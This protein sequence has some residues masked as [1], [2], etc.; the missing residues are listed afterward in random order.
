MIEEIEKRI[1]KLRSLSNDLN[2][3]INDV[4]RANASFVI[5]LNVEQQQSGVNAKNKKIGTY[6]ESTKKARKRKGLQ[7]SFVDLEVT[8]NYHK[9]FAITYGKNFIELTA[10]DVLYTI[11]LDNHYPDLFGLT[12]TNMEKLRGKIRPAIEA[13]LQKRL[14]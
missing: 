6:A 10:P 1:T 2:V 9:S 11:F 12:D 14:S 3:I 5:Q 13:E 7:T 4:L 8:K